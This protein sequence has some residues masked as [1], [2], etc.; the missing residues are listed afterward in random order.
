MNKLDYQVKISEILNNAL[1][2]LDVDD[3]DELVISIIE[4]IKQDYS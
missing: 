1:D 3:F 4:A 2:E